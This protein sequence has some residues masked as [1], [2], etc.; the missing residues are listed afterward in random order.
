MNRSIS[1]LLFGVVSDTDA[2]CSKSK[3]VFVVCPNLVRLLFHHVL[4]RSRNFGGL[5][6]TPYN[7]IYKKTHSHSASI[8]MSIAIFTG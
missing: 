3:P 4:P 8:I 7:Y 5:E 6:W 1:Y 2:R